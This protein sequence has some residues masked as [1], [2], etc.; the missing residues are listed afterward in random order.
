MNKIIRRF[1]IL[2]KNGAKLGVDAVHKGVIS[3]KLLYVRL[4]DSMDLV[5]VFEKFHIVLLIKTYIVKHGNF[6]V[7]SIS[8]ISFF[9]RLLFSRQFPDEF[10]KTIY[11]LLVHW[12]QK[13]TE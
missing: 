10:G 6:I 2:A 3:E 8:N 11:L 5:F 9:P 7:R 12:N 1:A 4:Q 13:P